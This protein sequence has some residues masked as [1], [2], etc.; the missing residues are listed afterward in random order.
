MMAGLPVRGS[1]SRL[2]W[3]EASLIVANSG[4]GRGLMGSR[5][6]FP[7]VLTFLLGVFAPISSAASVGSGGFVPLAHPIRINGSVA[8]IG[9]SPTNPA[10][11]PTDEQC[12]DQFKM[13]CYSPQEMQRA[14]NLTPLLT[15][16]HDGAGQTIVIIDSY[17]SPTIQ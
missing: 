12:R 13:P 16:G 7:V 3:R 8:H 17:G 9:R 11:P 10:Q 1:V 14:Y 6:L 5:G 4:R 2:S 15:A